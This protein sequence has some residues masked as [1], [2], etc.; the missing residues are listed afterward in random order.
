MV[1]VG[2]WLLVPRPR[3]TVA[4]YWAAGGGIFTIDAITFG[5]E[6][7]VGDLWLIP[8]SFGKRLPAVVRSWIEPRSPYLKHMTPEDAL[9]IWVSQSNVMGGVEL[10]LADAGGREWRPMECRQTLARNGTIRNG[11]VFAMYPRTT[12]RLHAVLTQTVS[13]VS[14]SIEI[15][16]LLPVAL[17]EWHPETLPAL[18]SV[19]D[20]SV[21]LSRLNR[22]TDVTT[23]GPYA[24]YQYW[25]PEARLLWHGDLVAGW[26]PAT[27]Q[28]FDSQGNWGRQLGMDFEALRYRITF[29]P[30]AVNSNATIVLWSAPSE[31]VGQIG[32]NSVWN[33]AFKHRGESIKLVGQF[34]PGMNVFARGE[35]S[36][37]YVNAPMPNS[38]GKTRWNWVQADGIDWHGH[39]TDRT[40]VYLHV[41]SEEIGRNI[42]LRVR[43][44]SG[45]MWPTT[46][47]P[48]GPRGGVI[49]FM[50]DLPAEVTG[51]VPE[52]VWLNPVEAEFTV[53]TPVGMT[54]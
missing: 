11:Y 22:R 37:N 15:T 18:K 1:L 6:H 52:I 8:E 19:G 48:L 35:Y 53:R 46:R 33:V 23:A 16:G 51:V 32:S 5:K 44:P 47:E 31:I 34:N 36:S 26:E 39:V 25:E 27:W 41:A 13:G 20:Y 12:N 42:G 7:E 54:P 3:V 49:P 4:N 21:V 17:T 10:V 50:L 40:T 28:V 38:R 30:R 24:K 45:R 2:A 14:H 43:D 9:T 29:Y